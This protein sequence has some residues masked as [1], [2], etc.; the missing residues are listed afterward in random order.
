MC[1]YIGWV[2]EEKDNSFKRN[3]ILASFDGK[4]L[5]KLYLMEPFF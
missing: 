5:L 2:E 4:P 3:K 1:T